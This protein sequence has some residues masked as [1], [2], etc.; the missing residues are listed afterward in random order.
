MNA[1]VRNS[2]TKFIYLS[3]TDKHILTIYGY[4]R[5]IENNRYGL[6]MPFD[7][8]QIIYFYY[9]LRIIKLIFCDKN[10]NIDESKYITRGILTHH[11]L[12]NLLINVKYF[13]ICQQINIICN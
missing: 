11:D 13:N 2:A 12:Y 10:G 5:M 6:P 3:H 1:L 9:I 7:I 4:I 8:H